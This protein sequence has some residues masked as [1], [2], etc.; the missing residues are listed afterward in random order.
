[1]RP[2]FH[3]LSFCG[4]DVRR[5]DGVDRIEDAHALTF[6][7][8]SAG[9]VLLLETL[10]HVE[11]PQRVV[12]EA[13]RV[14]TG[15]GLLLVSVPFTYRLHGY[16]A[17]YWRFTATGVRLLLAEFG[18]SVIFSV[19]PRVKPAFVFAAAT[20]IGSSAFA[21]AKADF[22][23]A[24]VAALTPPSLRARWSVVKDRGR[25]FFGLLLGRAELS[26]QFVDDRRD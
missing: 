20:P 25:D 13:R 1:M 26:V 15:A 17:D 8:G 10:E 19:G 24:V 16:P 18:D 3:G 22:R 14:L 23:Q 12:A 6:A 7:D 21:A 5:G 11:S 4:C 9:T 2:L